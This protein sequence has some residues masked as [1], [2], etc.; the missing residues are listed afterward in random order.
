[1]RKYAFR[2]FHRWSEGIG[3]DRKKF[4]KCV[5]VGIRSWFPS[6]AYIGFQPVDD[7]SARRRAVDI[8][9][10]ALDNLW[11]VFKEGQWVLDEEY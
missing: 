6:R 5:E 4:S 1:M 9:G 3:G 2:L 10:D 7:R 8:N 11:W